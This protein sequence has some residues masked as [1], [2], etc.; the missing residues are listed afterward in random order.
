MS[1]VAKKCY[2][3]WLRSTPR[4][5]LSR[6]DRGYLQDD[7]DWVA[8]HPRLAR[9]LDNLTGATLYL[10]RDRR[11]FGGVRY[12]KGTEFVPV[13]RWRHYL[14]GHLSGVAGLVAVE[15]AWVSSQRVPEVTVELPLNRIQ[16]RSRS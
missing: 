10:V 1:P 3:E 2:I 15:A 14:Y 6:A 8:D 11:S 9:K 4:E 13:F 12:S 16:A 7:L 5:E